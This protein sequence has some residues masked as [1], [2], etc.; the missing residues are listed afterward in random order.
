MR[1]A[2]KLLHPSTLLLVAA[3]AL[4][5][6]GIYV[7]GWD[8]FLLLILYWMETVIIGFWMIVGLLLAPASL[9]G[10]TPRYFLV[11][12]FLVHAGI[13]MTVHFAFLWDLFSG[14]WPSRVHGARDFVGA[15]VIETGL[16]IPLAAL[17]VSRGVSL[18]YLVFGPSILPAWFIGQRDISAAAGDDHPLAEG[19]LI[20]GFYSRIVIMHLTILFGAVI[21]TAFGSMGPLL[22]MVALKIAIDLKLHVRNDFPRSGPVIVTTA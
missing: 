20:G 13:F 2:A 21:A 18:L 6:A 14:Q 17:F 7:W 5:L 10:R 22:L 16:W 3:N 1:I 9:A 19:R 8:V 12:F 15:I 4:P 11:P